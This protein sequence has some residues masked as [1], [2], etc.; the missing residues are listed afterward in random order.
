MKSYI[1]AICTSRKRGVP[2]SPQKEVILIAN[3]GILGDAH[4]GSGH[5]QVSLLAGEQIDQFRK[6]LPGL[7]SGAFGENIITRGLELRELKQEDRLI[8]G[9]GVVLEITQIGKECHKPCAIQ[10]RTGECI[11]PTEGLFAR[12]ITG[13]RLKP[14]DIIRRYRNRTGKNQKRGKPLF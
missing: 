9:E 4:A 5:R 8:C 10:L 7:E 1:E 11:M 14:G 6:K 2:K 12:V 3:T 13:G